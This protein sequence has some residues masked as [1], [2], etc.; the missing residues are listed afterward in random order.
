MIRKV[1]STCLASAF[2]VASLIGSQ[3]FAQNNVLRWKMEEGQKFKVEM[4]MSAE[5]KMNT[6]GG[7]ME[8]PV[9]QVAYMDWEVK[10]VED[11]KFQMTQK[12]TRMKMNMDSPDDAN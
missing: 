6:P 1:T 3:T 8:I 5:Q 2:V 12:I 9:E 11:G 7:A 4:T 10:K